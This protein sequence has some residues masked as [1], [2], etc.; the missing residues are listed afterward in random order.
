MTIEKF[1]VNSV[2]DGL[3]LSCVA[4]LPEGGRDAAKG[5]FQILHGMC[6]YKE[7]YD[8]FMRFLAE[9][10]FVA[11]AHDH[12][13]HGE[14]V[15]EKADLGYFYEKTGT[16]IV[17]DA[18]C[19]TEEVKK[20]YE[21]L[22]VVLMGHS[23]GSMVARCYLGESEALA[24]LVVSG[25]PSENPMAEAGI[26]LTKVIGFFKGERHR[27]GTLRKLTLGGG[28]KAFPGEGKN[29]WLTRDKAIVEKYN[30]DEK[31]SFVF[32]VNGF[33]NLLRL[34]DRTYDDATYK[35]GNPDL[36]IF[37]VAGSAD[38]IIVD[39][40]SWAE[41]QAALR[42][43]GYKKV[44]GKLYHGMRHEVLNEQGKEEVYQDILRFANEC[45]C[46]P[47]KK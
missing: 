2:F 21:G 17:K 12:R 15:K 36:P 23:M 18:V 27:S 31:C 45:I 34:M 37:F 25:S 10:G 9:N 42:T 1:S 33:E 26:V 30:A 20:K 19:V 7:R 44:S 41:A 40:D 22:P 43:V 6:E 35:V 4:Y 16:A 38:P 8:G 28:D 47:R 24:G 32:T 46:P 3:E 11:V 39:E 5:I 14:S 29:A 13:G